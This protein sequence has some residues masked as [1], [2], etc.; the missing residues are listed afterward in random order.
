MS[1]TGVHYILVCEDRQHESFCRAFLKRRLGLVA[2]DYEQRRRP[3]GNFSDTRDAAV[4]HVRDSFMPRSHR[5]ALIVMFDA[6]KHGA[7]RLA[8]FWNRVADIEKEKGR[9]ADR[10][11]ITVLIPARNIETWLEALATGNAV[12]EIATYRK[13]EGQEA[14]IKPE[15]DRLATACENGQQPDHWPE[16]L[17][18]ACFEFEKLKAIPGVTAR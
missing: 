13:R 5:V 6:D 8:D 14:A 10:D 4:Q 1:R 12:D 7:A 11:A 18:T 2:A 15:I 9:S 17:K 16:S 3:V